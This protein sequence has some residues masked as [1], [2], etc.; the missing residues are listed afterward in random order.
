MSYYPKSLVR[1]FPIY[2]FAL[3]IPVFFLISV[4][5]YEPKGLCELMRAGEGLSMIS[6]VYT[7]N[8]IITFTIL[9]AAMSLSR[10]LLWLLRKA[11][12]MDMY[13]YCIWCMGE[14]VV[15]GAFVS[16]YL[17]LMAR[18]D[19]GW[20]GWLGR[21]IVSI[22]SISIFPY[23]ILTLF[24]CARE[25]ATAHDASADARLKF[26]DNR[27]QLKFITEASSVLYIESN[28]NYII[29][30]YLEN[31]IE[32]RF[33][34][35]TSMKNIE[36]LCEQAGFARAHRCYIVNPLHVKSIRKGVGGLNFADLGTGDDGI[37]I[38]KKYYEGIAA[39]L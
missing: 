1:F 23:L 17:V 20:F 3:A 13:K 22:G 18:G 37:P 32:K 31:A 5:L 26:Y 28:E 14:I 34:I 12:A 35:R 30:H 8:I 25:K 6:N 39:M 9:L 15:C 19:G 36:P 11:L 2:V 4:L 38:S 27:H 29:V 7:F 16:L 21:S 10:V 24:I 33:Q